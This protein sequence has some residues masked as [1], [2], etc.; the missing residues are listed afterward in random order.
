M[1]IALPS[2]W[3]DTGTTV[4]QDME[5]DLELRAWA[6]GTGVGTTMARWDNV[7][8]EF[9]TQ[10]VGASAGGGGFNVGV[11]AYTTVRT[12]LRDGF[13]TSV[14]NSAASTCTGGGDGGPP[15]LPAVRLKKT[16]GPCAWGSRSSSAP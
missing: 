15:W 8:L 1:P 9:T 7:G 5:A 13:T 3:L 12:I 16:F 10:G 4:T 6:E 11:D 2:G 14:L